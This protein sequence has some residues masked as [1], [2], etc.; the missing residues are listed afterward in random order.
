V[1]IVLV[2]TARALR[3]TSVT[4]VEVLVVGGIVL[5]V[6]V[7][8]AFLLPQ[9]RTSA[10]A[11]TASNGSAKRAGQAPIAGA[12]YPLPPLDLVVPPPPPRRAAMTATGAGADGT[13]DGG[14]PARRED[15]H[16]TA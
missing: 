8:V 14:P 12:D 2:S 15:G 1:W 7:I 10:Q 11:T 16:G 4:P 5:V 3:S 13:T 6:L 9:G